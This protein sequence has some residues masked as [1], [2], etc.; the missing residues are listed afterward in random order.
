[1]TGADCL[2]LLTDHDAYQTLDPAQIGA[3]MRR[4]IVFDTRGTIDPPIW[5]A[6]GFQVLRL[7]DGTVGTSDG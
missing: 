7:G 3:L 6:A 5:R 4:R 2:V 1:M